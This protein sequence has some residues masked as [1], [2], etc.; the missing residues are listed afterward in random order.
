[1]IVQRKPRVVVTN[2]VHGEVLAYLREHCEVVAN[3]TRQALSRDQV[4]AQ[5]RKADGLLAFMPD[6]VDAAFLDACPTLRVIGCA[7][8]GIDNFDAEACAERGVW[9]TAVSDLLTEPTAELAV[10]LLIALMRNVMAGDREV[11]AGRFTGWRATLYGA[12]LTGMP[13]GLLGMGA[14]GTAVARRLDAFGARLTYA[15]PAVTTLDFGSFAA[16][17]LSF[18]PLLENSGVLVI[19]A[20]LTPTSRHLVD[21]AAI[22]RIRPGAYVINV[23]RGSVV[24]EEAIAAALRNGRLAGYAADVFS[25]EDWAL[26]DRPR[27]IPRSLLDHRERTLFTPHLGSAV[28]EVRREIAYVAAESILEALDGRRPRGAVNQPQ[29]ARSAETA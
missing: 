14:V 6:S 19:S 22:A 3:Q 10:G 12:T 8:R 7:A 11:R 29:F 20:P 15:D 26:A 9:L 2:W 5:A 23:G 18:E 17:R 1:M 24:D 21:S 27:A 16:T 4:I 13:V 28:D 25:F